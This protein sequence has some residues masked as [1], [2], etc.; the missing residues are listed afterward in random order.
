MS[1]PRDPSFEPADGPGRPDGSGGPD[2]SDRPTPGAPPPLTVAASL[3][4]LQGL[5]LLLLAL[6][7]AANVESSRASLGIST[8]AFFGLYAVVLLAAATG[9]ARRATW[10]R[11]PALF[12]Q[13]VGLGLAWN[14]RDLWLVAVLLA[15]ASVVAL[16]GLVH[17][18]TVAALERGGDEAK[19]EPGDG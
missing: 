7:E 19:A 17:P 13:L 6:A 4:G 5:V 8:A 18:D 14:L 9:L 2:G 11:G 3:V 1:T 12:T 10:A 16:I 15:V